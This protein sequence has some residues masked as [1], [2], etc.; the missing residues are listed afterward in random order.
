[1]PLDHLHHSIHQATQHFLNAQDMLVFNVAVIGVIVTAWFQIIPA[2]AAILAIVWY[3]IL[4][5]ESRTIRKLTGRTDDI[6]DQPENSDY[7]GQP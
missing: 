5:W 6:D 2:V 1:M 3:G 7:D 4:I